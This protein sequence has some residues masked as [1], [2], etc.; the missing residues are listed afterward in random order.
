MR[1]ERVKKISK[2]ILCSPDLSSENIIKKNKLKKTIFIERDA[3][4]ANSNVSIYNSIKLC[5]K[6]Y[7]NKFKKKIDSLVISKVVTPFLEHMHLENAMNT[8]EIFNLDAVIGIRPI[9][10]VLFRH[11]GKTLSPLRYNDS[12]YDKDTNV[13]IL[14]E[15]QQIYSE[16]GNFFGY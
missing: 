5:I 9:D 4:L 14:I 10:D 11:N 15:A 13:K 16:A 7:E 3:N 1:L 2:V 12:I 6:K 8:C